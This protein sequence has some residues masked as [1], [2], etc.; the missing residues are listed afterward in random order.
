MEQGTS[1]L[2]PTDS[3]AIQCQRL[4]ERIKDGELDASELE[5]N[6]AAIFDLL[7]EDWLSSAFTVQIGST[8]RLLAD[9]GMFAGMDHD[10]VK[11]VSDLFGNL[12][13]GAHTRI[14]HTNAGR[15]VEE[16][17]EIFEWPAPLLA[18]SLSEFLGDFHLTMET[19]VIAELTLLSHFVEDSSLRTKCQR[20]L[21][22]EVL[23]AAN[24][25][26]VTRL[27]QRWAA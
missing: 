9:W 18:E 15:A 27:L 21:E 4:P 5:A 7:R 19:M 26:Q 24:L 13:A 12:S 23:A 6:S 11:T 17:A 2:K 14:T 22:N 3:L 25:A 20:L 10:P 8:V 16:G 1:S